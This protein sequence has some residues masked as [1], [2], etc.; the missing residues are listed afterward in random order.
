[1]KFLNVG[2]RKQP[3]AEQ[4]MTTAD[5]RSDEPPPRQQSKL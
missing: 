3:L 2:K 4:A 1:M 5:E